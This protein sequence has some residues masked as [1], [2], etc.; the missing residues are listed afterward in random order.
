MIKNEANA[1]SKKFNVLFDFPSN[2]S[3][4]GNADSLN[5][6]IRNVFTS[7]I[8][9]VY[10]T[11]KLP[12]GCKYV[13]GSLNNNN[14]SEFNISD[15]NSPVFRLVDFT[16]AGYLKFSIKMTND[17]NLQ[18]F[19]SKGN[20][21]FVRL[22]L[23]Y[24]GGN[25]S[26]MS[27]NINVLIPNIL[28][29][30]ISNQVK[31][32]YINDVFV[33][34]ISI[35]NTGNGKVKSFVFLRKNGNGINVKSSRIAD[36]YKVDSIISKFDSSDFKKIGNKDK[37]FDSGEEIKIEDS[38]KVILCNNLNTVYYLKF[39]CNNTI[40]NSSTKNAIINL[41]AFIQGLVITPKSKINWC[42]DNNKP[43]KNE[44]I[45]INKSNKAINSTL[46]NI[47]QTWSGGFYNSQMSAIDTSSLKIAKGKWGKQLN[48]IFYGLSYNNSGSYF[49]CLGSMP[50]GGVNLLLGDM[51]VNDTIYISW[52]SIS[53]MPN[54]CNT[55]I[56]AH[57]WMYSASYK[58]QCNQNYN[59][60]ENWG[61]YGGAQYLNA[62]PWL[63]TD[64]A[65]GSPE[66]LNFTFTSASIIN[67]NA[68][69]QFVVKL[70][71][72]TGL[73]HSLKPDDL[74]F[75]D[76][77][78]IEW[79]PYR[80]Y[81][82]SKDIYAYFKNLNIT[83]L[84]AE[85]NILI[86]A[87]CKGASSGKKTYKLDILYKS[88]TTCNDTF[89]NLYCTSSQVN[90]HCKVYC[91]NGGMLFRGFKVLR[92]NYGLPDNNNDG[93]A[94]TSGTIDM[95]KVKTNISF[96]H[97]T[98]SANYSGLVFSSGSTNLFFNGR[99]KTSINNGNLITP[100]SVDL[101]IYRNGKLRY[102]CDK[103]KATSSVSGTVRNCELDFTSNA[104]KTAGCGN[105]SNYFF[106]N[107][108]SVVIS[109]N[110]VYT[111]S[112]DNYS[113]DIYFNNS[114]FYLSTTPN[115]TSYQK[116]QC[117]TF[118][119][120][121]ILSANY[122]T[123]YYTENY[124]S[125]TCGDITLSQSFYFSAGSCCNNYAGGNQFPY[126]Y[127]NFT[128][129]EKINVIIPTGYKFSGA[130]M[131]YYY[132]TGTNKYKYKYAS[133]LKPYKTVSDTLF[134]SLDTL[135]N[136]VKGIFP[137]SDEGYIATLQLKLIPTCQSAINTLEPVKYLS[138]FKWKANQKTDIVTNYL[139]FIQFN[140]PS[141]LL[142]PVNSNS[143]SSKD[144]F[145]WD[146]IITNTN[147]G[148]NINNLWLSNSTKQKADIIAIKDLSTGT[149][150]TKQ[151]DIFKAGNL[152]STTTRNFRIYAKSKNCKT[153]SIKIALG[154]NCD[155]YPDSSESFKCK[156]LLKYV[157][158]VLNPVP[159]L[160]NSVI[161]EDSSP[162]DVCTNRK[163]EVIIANTDEE[164]IFNLKLNVTIPQ[165]T[166]FV[167][168]GMY[169]SFPKN[170]KFIKLNK[171]TIS[172][173]NTYT[174][175]LSDSI[176]ALKQGLAKVSDT[177]KN[178]IKIQFYLETNCKI[179]ANSFVSVMPDGKMGCGEPVRKTGYT[180]KPIK[181]KGVDNPYSTSI[182]LNID[183]I[184]LCKPNI[185]LKAK[186]I[187]LG[188]VKTY[189]GDSIQLILPQGFVP[190]T[191]SLTS[192]KING[193]GNLK[194]VNKQ[195]YWLW[196]IPT[197]MSP[198]DSSELKF[199][200]NITSNETTCGNSDFSLTSFT[201]K[202]AFCVKSNDSCD[203]KAAT[204]NFIKSTVLQKSSPIITLIKSV[205]T[206][207][208]DSGEIADIAFSI[209][210]NKSEIDTAYSVFYYLIADRNS[211]S[212][213]DSS[214]FIISKFTKN[215]GLSSNQILNYSFNGFIRNTDVCR[216]FIASDIAN[217]HCSEI[218]L[219]IS[220]LQLSNAGRDTSF[221]SNYKIKIGIDS[222]K[223]Y[224]YEWF[225]STYIK[226]PNSSE[227]EYFKKN[228]LNTEEYKI[229]FLKTTKPGSCYSID[230]IKLVSKPAILL[231]KLKD[232]INLCSGKNTIIGDTA[233]GGKG[234]LTF[235]WTPS[236][237]LSS[238]N[239]MIVYTGTLTPTKYYINIKDQNNC[240][241]SDS[242][243]IK[244]SKAPKVK[245]AYTGKCEKK[246]II[247][248]D[249][250]NYFGD[251]PGNTTWRINFNT[252]YQKSP[253]YTFDTLG[254]Y[255]V[256]L[257]AENQYGCIDSAFKYVNIF[258]N[259]IV[260]N[261]KQ[262]FCLGD[263]TTFI[264]NSYVALNKIKSVLWEFASD[265]SFGTLIKKTFTS[266]GIQYFKQIAESDSGCFSEISDSFDIKL[267]PE[268]DFY[269][270]KNCEKDTILFFDNSKY[271]NNDSIIFNIWKINR[272]TYNSSNVS[273][274]F[275]SFGTYKIFH[276]VKTK[277]N[278]ID[279]INQIITI[280]PKPL[281]QFVSKDFCPADTILIQS[282]SNIKN[283]NIIK[284]KWV[285]DDTV[286]SS[287]NLFTFLNLKEG[288]H[289]LKHIVSSDYL[290]SDSISKNLTIYPSLN[291]KTKIS[292]SCE[293][294]TVRLADITEQK[295]SK[296][297]L[298][299][300]V[301]DKKYYSDSTI[302]VNTTIKG[303]YYFRFIVKS[304]ENCL[305]YLD[306]NYLVNE[307]P[308]SDFINLSKCNDNLIEFKDNSK[309]EINTKI[310]TRNWYSDGNLIN[311]NDTF[312][313]HKFVSDG[314]N[315]IKLIVINSNKC[316]DTVEK[317][318]N[319][320]KE[321]YA[322]FTSND[323]CES[324][325]VKLKFTGYTGLN[326]ITITNINWGDGFLSNKLP[327]NHTYKTP[328]KYKI[329]YKIET[330]SNCIFDTSAIVTIYELP[331][332]SFEYY[333]PFP[334]IKNSK[335]TIT[336]KSKNAVS[337][338]YLLS[339]G[340]NL[341][342][343]NP[344]YNFTDTGKFTITQFAVSSN[345]CIDTAIKNV[346]V[347]FILL[348]YIPTA[349]SPGNDE[350][351]PL[352]S[353]E[354]LGIKEYRMLIFNRWGEKVFESDWGKKPWNGTYKGEFVLPGIYHYFIQIR[355]YG[356]IRHDQTGIITV[357]R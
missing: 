29:N 260:K 101:R 265:S 112:I 27:G 231:P 43:T 19:I 40:C 356:N 66:K 354:G 79:K 113:G 156:N 184:N 90:V 341:N 351:N 72:Q 206:V 266:P 188:P 108:D 194:E 23:T 268:I 313:K 348:T 34:Q 211:N 209:K 85:L 44:L 353:P 289:I 217:C 304:D 179:T 288:K 50:I 127:R 124:S 105:F 145:S 239:K 86:N 106:L 233:K 65:V 272:S 137:T 143:I 111:T 168:T 298:R 333:P 252:T 94:D 17:C 279:S 2:I 164:N 150:L 78:G 296:I 69:S 22:D 81:Y 237:G 250:S 88:D 213:F 53:C 234:T 8:T 163:F 117:D 159:P 204:G 165:G 224:K 311:I 236:A 92:K 214:D 33:R 68:K 212:K 61:S 232:T 71:L 131:Y 189:N 251:K 210:N 334:D 130:G 305:F 246:D 219:P 355:D 199:K 300:W 63:P 170:N 97:D 320:L 158:L 135:F 83:L 262:N 186:I 286:S 161:Y 95:K 283:G 207:A 30:S 323:A 270:V 76:I 326:S 228:I 122:F 340:T 243:Y 192:I 31:N 121:H 45:V 55:T 337:W 241:I 80:I 167:D 1:Q 295:K 46:I 220:S 54:V 308:Q 125:N 310:T 275:D 276:L 328:G 126:E 3:I 147:S 230:T 107:K 39:G 35:K 321:N 140:H 299:S 185:E 15:L 70:N 166:S 153:D 346:Y 322:A 96:L 316:T 182:K 227:T 173:G 38:V 89:F 314:L 148:S 21:A 324:D 18:S 178:K 325:T 344:D 284:Y 244:I 257:I 225:P 187:Y 118:A 195:I 294:D 202:K 60:A 329:S 215:K 171:P 139:D 198:G 41:D 319:I 32:S 248:A 330:L 222:I 347:N 229:Y 303:S 342:N 309:T 123:D 183:T 109:I 24:N 226:S 267:R 49:S 52:N 318:I 200:L 93:I 345:G 259:P 57:R 343:Q 84:K 278:C 315:T 141:I 154:W 20:Q 133:G 240:K 74:K 174:W 10:A 16:L 151:N 119:G 307:K 357:I 235:L 292:I 255:F 120:R 160:I 293:Y 4:C 205:S 138:Y 142:S 37:Y 128:D 104:A 62:L 238:N 177:L 201:K 281:A 26:H 75:V 245:I 172:F 290:C 103:L 11:I 256:R 350:H 216:L 191:A 98:L 99:L 136:P 218:L 152:S 327:F 5:F 338:N 291:P 301:F 144:T 271:F 317:T 331:Q 91:N 132:T 82:D 332:A 258:A 114:E 269:N 339:N 157:N 149:F 58:D 162:T 282:N 169:Y 59:V 197:G 254:L 193:K 47:Y 280:N 274:S 6:E 64:I 7:G 48:K 277:S 302:N 203:V 134:F 242:V 110:F 175:H 77:D 264:D 287:G 335:I 14:I 253:I 100:Y 208:G 180:G 312:F 9:N 190:D 247:F 73:K 28:I 51:L 42:F 306:T 349:F 285:I 221:C 273:V 155:N 336:D 129:F 223:S 36:S 249:S 12:S 352:F 115:P 87:E 67:V 102:F 116:L 196:S 181:I 263:S 25:E 13:G 297:K 176:S 146:I 56:V 261:V